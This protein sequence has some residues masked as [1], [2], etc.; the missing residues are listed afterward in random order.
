M[1]K[2]TQHYHYII[3]HLIDDPII[4]TFLNNKE[5]YLLKKQYFYILL[6]SYKISTLENI[7]FDNFY[8]FNRKIQ[9][10]FDDVINQQISYFTN[11]YLKLL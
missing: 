10:F 6:E 9:A 1:K 5:N 8:S 2:I 3:S 7:N 11:E 4:F